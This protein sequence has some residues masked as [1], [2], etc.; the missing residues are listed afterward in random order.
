[1]YVGSIR[2]IP[3]QSVYI[4]KKTFKLAKFAMQRFCN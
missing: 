3:N 4:Y 2:N 1:M